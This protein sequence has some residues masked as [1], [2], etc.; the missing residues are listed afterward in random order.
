MDYPNVKFIVK[1]ITLNKVSTR[2]TFTQYQ[3]NPNP[4]NWGWNGW[5]IQEDLTV[6]SGD[7]E[8]TATDDAGTFD[9]LTPNATDYSIVLPQVLKDKIDP[10]LTIV[11]E[12]ITSY[13]GTEVKETVRD[14]KDLKD[15]YKN[16]WECN[17]KYVL[18]ITLGLNE[19]YWDPSVVGWEDGTVTDI[20]F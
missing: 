19:I 8:V 3:S 17:K 18:G 16:D 2:G 5:G 15:I 13:T 10:K 6:F 1:S 12:I 20:P 14:T 11:Y 9:K 7:K 4:E